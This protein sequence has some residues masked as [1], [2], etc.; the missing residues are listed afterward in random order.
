MLKIPENLDIPTS[1]FGL[2]NQI[3][4]TNALLFYIFIIKF[5]LE[6]SHEKNGV[7]IKIAPHRFEYDSYGW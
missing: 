4:L 2:W 6:L 7:C 5:V 1:W 3:F